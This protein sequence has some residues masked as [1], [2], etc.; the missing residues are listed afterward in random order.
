MAVTSLLVTPARALCSGICRLRKRPG[1]C[2][3]RPSTP[4]LPCELPTQPL[5]GE[6]LGAWDVGCAAAIRGIGAGGVLATREKADG[7]RSSPSHLWA[8]P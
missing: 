8:C 4:F 7:N 1:L 2:C 6:S 5:M 3:Q